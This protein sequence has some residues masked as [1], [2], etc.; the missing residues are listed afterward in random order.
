MAS[1]AAWRDP[2]AFALQ[3]ATPT[4]EAVDSALKFGVPLVV[5]DAEHILGSKTCKA[6]T[7]STK[8]TV[9]QPAGCDTPWTVP[10][11]VKA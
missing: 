5:Y 3:T 7:S 10:G 8:S 4:Q 11:P 6:S 9:E 2:R 1:L